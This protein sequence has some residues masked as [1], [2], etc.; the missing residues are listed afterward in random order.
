MKGEYIENTDYERFPDRGGGAYLA[1]TST[2]Q[3]FSG[4]L[5]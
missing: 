4:L 3:R 1:I 2:Q 5:L